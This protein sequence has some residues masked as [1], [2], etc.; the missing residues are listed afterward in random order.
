MRK[1]ILASNLVSS[2]A[3]LLCAGTAAAEDLA[4]EPDAPVHSRTS[5]RALLADLFGGDDEAAAAVPVPE[6]S[7]GLEAELGRRLRLELRYDSRGPFESH[8]TDP[9]EAEHFVFLQLRARL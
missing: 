5:V 1:R 2:A 6:D 9:R 3:L 4:A 7:G 8:L